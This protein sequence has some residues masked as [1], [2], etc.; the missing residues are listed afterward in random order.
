MNTHLTFKRLLFSNC[1]MKQG[2]LRFFSKMIRH[3]DSLLP[4][5]PVQQAIRKAQAFCFDVDSTVITTEGIDELAA[6]KG[7]LDQVAALTRGAMGGQVAFRDAL[8]SRL[9]L[10]NPS[11]GD[12]KNFLSKHP[13]VFTPRLEEVIQ[14]LQKKQIDIY[15]VSGG[16]TQMIFPIAKRLNIPENRVYANTIL[17][18]EKGAYKGFDLNAPTSKDGGKTEVVR[19]LRS[20]YKY[21]EVVMIGDGAT[22][23]Q[24]RT[25][26]AATAF[27]GYGG[28]VERKIVKEGAD[29]FIYGWDA[30]LNELNRS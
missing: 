10:I 27:I 15:L 7:C 13:F 4:S 22:D 28:I 29:W 19:K 17:F 14:T 18:D 2:G 30:L 25:S 16:F 3:S 6:Y 12:M 26:D 8:S 5:L 24:A 9:S 21:N 23:L 1:C 20:T 11:E